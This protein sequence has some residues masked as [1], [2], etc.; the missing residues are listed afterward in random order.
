MT[1]EKQSEFSKYQY[2]KEMPYYVYGQSPETIRIYLAKFTNC[3][4]CKDKWVDYN[5]L[6]DHERFYLGYYGKYMYV[7]FSSKKHPTFGGS[8]HHGDKIKTFDY[9]KFIY[10]L[11]RASSEKVSAFGEAVYP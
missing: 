4:R 11:V 2:D 3:A 1:N 5:E 7:Q 6:D 9:L 8:V 10:P